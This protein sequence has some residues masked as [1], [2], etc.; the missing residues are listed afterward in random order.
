M[1]KVEGQ[2]WMRREEWW[3]VAVLL[4]DNCR[5]VDIGRRRAGWIGI[6]RGVARREREEGGGGGARGKGRVRLG[7]RSRTRIYKEQLSNVGSRRGRPRSAL[8][9]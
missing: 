6:W 8:G 9:E 7:F 2:R 5:T 1:G 3:T 4:L